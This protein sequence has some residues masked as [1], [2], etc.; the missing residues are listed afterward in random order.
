MR[1]LF[2]RKESF[3]KSPPDGV[4]VEHDVHDAF[5]VGLDVVDHHLGPMLDFLKYVRQK[6]AIFTSVFHFLI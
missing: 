3:G 4:V 1:K 2:W 6:I 5:F